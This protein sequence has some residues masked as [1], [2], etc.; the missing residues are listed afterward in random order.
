MN[1]TQDPIPGGPDAI[2]TAR[3]DER[4]AHAYDQI[5][6]ADEQ[7]ARVTEQL[8]KMEHDSMRRPAQLG[9]GRPSRD[10]PALRGLLGVFLAGCIGAVAFASQ[11]PYGE[12]ARAT[13]AQWAPNLVSNSPLGVPKPANVTPGP[14]GVQ[15]AAA[16]AT[17]AQLTTS[18][19]A[20][21]QDVAPTPA[22]MSPELVQMLQTMAHDIAVVEQGIEELKANQARMAAD[23]ARAI[24]QLKASQEQMTRTAVAKPADKPAAPDPRA[25]T[26]APPPGPVASAARKP[27]PK[28][29]A[30]ARAQS[31]PVQLQP[32]DR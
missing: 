16:E 18:A 8:A 22:P 23:N 10:R 28:Q 3:A 7:L 21:A 9:G 31:Q 30:Q 12:G 29:P 13:I 27:P 6:R 1:S 17:P 19:Q 5:A 32:R 15:L 4:L 11:S 20:P 2:L 26:P 24:E 25:K 14:S